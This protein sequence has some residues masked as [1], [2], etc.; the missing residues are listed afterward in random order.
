VRIDPAGDDIGPFGIDIFVAHEVLTK[1]QQLLTEDQPEKRLELLE[2]L[3][4]RS[5]AVVMAADVFLTN[6]GFRKYRE[7]I[8]VLQAEMEMQ[9]KHGQKVEV[10]ASASDIAALLGLHGWSEEDDEG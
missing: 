8:G 7:R 6:I 10:E 3:F 2:G 5:K 9:G 1:E 4:S